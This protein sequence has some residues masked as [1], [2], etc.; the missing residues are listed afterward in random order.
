VHAARQRL[1]V[2]RLGILAVDAV[3]DAA[4]QREIAQTLRGVGTFGH[5]RDRAT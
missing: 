3:T 1:D 2:E 4:Q 5:V